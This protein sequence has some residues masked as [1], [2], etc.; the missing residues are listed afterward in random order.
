MKRLVLI[1]GLLVLFVPEI[2]R[3]YFI[4][5]F[6]GSQHQ[7]TIGLAYWISNNI[8]LI[9]IL[10]LVLIIF[11]LINIFKSGKTWLKII[12]SLTLLF[13]AVVFFLFNYRFEADKMFYQPKQK[14]FVHGKMES[15][16][17]VGMDHFNAMFEDAT[18]KSWWQQATG[19]AIAGP[20]KGTA[21]REI[22]SKQLTLESWL[23]EYPNSYILQPDTTF[24]KDYKDLAG[25]D[26]GTLKS[27]LEKRDSVSWKPKSWV[28]GVVH[29]H[30]A[31]AYDWNELVK[32]KVINDSIEGLPVLLGL[33]RDTASFHVYDRRVKGTIL[34]FQKGSN[35]VFTDE[36]TNSTW[37]MDGV[38]INGT[39]K[40]ERLNPVQAYQEF[41]HSW[42]TF[43]PN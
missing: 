34:I 8:G 39:L 6:P 11:P 32:N 1:S 5:P 22:V 41:W 14:L 16:R 10:G 21:L 23:R 36:N 19:K 25:Y 37:N 30:I 33:E 13:Y 17:L 4:M 28:I 29:N 24:K 3:V 26:K 31:K 2:L 38:C 27:G 15:F 12:L 18:T 20:L 35:D 9:R 7:N 40:G 43:H 42:S